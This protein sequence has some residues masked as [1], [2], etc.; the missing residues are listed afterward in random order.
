MSGIFN[1]QAIQDLG[2]VN[3]QIAK[4]LSK[5]KTKP[6]SNQSQQ[7][8]QQQLEQQA[9]MSAHL[10][11]L[12]QYFQNPAFQSTQ[13]GQT[14]GQFQNPMGM[15]NT[16]SM[17]PYLPESGQGLT[18]PV[19]AQQLFNQTIQGQ[20][21]KYSS[22][23][24]RSLKNITKAEEMYSKGVQFVN[25]INELLTILSTNFSS[26]SGQGQAETKIDPKFQKLQKLRQMFSKQSSSSNI[27]TPKYTT[28][29]LDNLKQKLQSLLLQFQIE[30]EQYANYLTLF[31]S[32]FNNPSVPLQQIGQSPLTSSI[33]I[34]GLNQTQLGD[35]PMKPHSG[36]Y[37]ATRQLFDLFRVLFTV[38]YSTLV[39]DI[40]KLQQTLLKSSPNQ[41]TELISSNMKELPKVVEAIVESLDTRLTNL[42]EIDS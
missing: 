31:N 17:N 42:Q 35:S 11:N 28:V 34:H 4:N 8:Q 30:L 27:Q 33:S 36:L 24:K 14:L 37:M 25:M 3:P 12:N 22:Q 41:T 19:A 13:Y 39:N 15:L 1:M 29:Y 32:A 38:I 18:D 7:L 10:N 2:L 16:Y 40:M 21:N 6:N 5:N 9:F 23:S 20:M 26:I